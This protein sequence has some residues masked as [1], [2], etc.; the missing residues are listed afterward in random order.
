[1]TAIALSTLL[2]HGIATTAL[3]IGTALASCFTPRR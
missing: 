2:I 1:M 3:A